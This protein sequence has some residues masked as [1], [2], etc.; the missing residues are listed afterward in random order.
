MGMPALK[1]EPEETSVT[2][3]ERLARLESNVEHIQSDVSDV[4]VEI[5]H[6]SD[7]MDD[8]RDRVDD[9]KDLVANLA[10]ATEKS[11]SKL[12]LWAIGLYIGLGVGLFT[13]IAHAFHW[14]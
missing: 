8:L 3:E 12:S 9:L 5:R 10:L 11:L 14:L 2:V 4:K 6:L 1:L 7:K 13:F